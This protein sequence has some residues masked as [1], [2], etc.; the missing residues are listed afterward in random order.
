MSTLRRIA[1]LLLAAGLAVT[2]LAQS[3]DYYV[4]SL[5]WAPAFC[6]QPGAAAR[7]PQ[8]CATGKGIAFI[9]HGLWPEIAGGRGPESCGHAGSL[10]R[11]VVNYALP[12]MLSPGLIRHEWETH[13]TCTGLKPFDYISNIVQ[14]RS[15]I[16]IPVQLSSIDSPVMETPGQVETQFADANPSFPRSAFRTHCTGSVFEE[17]RICFDKNLKPRACPAN[18]AYCRS[19]TVLIPPPL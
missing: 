13:G 9:V 11:N 16:Q 1:G 7:N 5:S 4:L 2:L 14:A 10:P 8:E 18:A 12:Y 6:A 19:G 15:S 3:F 17:E